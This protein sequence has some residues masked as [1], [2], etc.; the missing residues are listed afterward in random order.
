MSVTSL[1]DSEMAAVS[2]STHFD[3]FD[4][5]RSFDVDL[6]LLDRNYRALQRS[7][8]PDRFVNASDQERRV[9]M[10]RAT[11]INEGYETLKDPLKRGR[12]LLELDGRAHDDERNTNSD[13]KFL[14]EQMELREAL[15][16]IRGREDAVQELGRIMDRIAADIDKL[17]GDL[18]DQFARADAESLDAAADTLTR[19][20]FFRRLQEEAGE[21]EADLE[22]ELA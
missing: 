22:D 10:Q 4:L 9:S 14:M 17:V 3:L 12:Y 19:M 8:H 16:E 13:M 21:L 7:V 5:P 2:S 20:Q 18:R 6:G 1:S 11:Q 15:G